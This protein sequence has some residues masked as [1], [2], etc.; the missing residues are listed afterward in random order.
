MTARIILLILCA[1][2]SSP[3]CARAADTNAV[4]NAWFATQTNLH[5][6]KASFTQTRTLKTLKQP[7]V[8]SG[9]VWF[10]LPNRYRWELGAPAQ[11]IALRQA[12]E[13]LVIYPVLKRAE[14]YPA[15][16]KAT[17]Q[18]RDAL[19][20]L[21]AGFPRDRA[22]LESRFRILSLAGANG[23]WTLTLQP[24]SSAAQRMMKEMRLGLATHDFLLVSTELVFVDGSTMRNDFTNAVLN[25]TFDAAVFDWTPPADFTI[26][27]PLGK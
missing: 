9:R 5:T 22:E 15:G 17:G 1:L 4:L 10:E 14:R 24:K 25:S 19:A 18:W 8:T 23:V 6:W 16:D 21:E 27:E 26:T 2:V 3:D 7:L 12:D 13:L 20:L 11:T